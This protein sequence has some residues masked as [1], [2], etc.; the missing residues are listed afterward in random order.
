MIK[1]R[2]CFATTLMASVW[3][4]E[5]VALTYTVKIV[6]MTSLTLLVIVVVL[7]SIIVLLLL[8]LI[9]VLVAM[10]VVVSIVIV[11]MLALLTDDVFGCHCG[12]PPAMPIGG[13][14]PG[15]KLLFGGG[16]RIP[17]PYVPAPIGPMPGPRG[18]F[19]LGF[20]GPIPGGPE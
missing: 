10:M 7:L 12:R 5:K 15:P 19:I 18:G 3:I 20:I 14:P 6:K 13:I 9:A 1:S 17:G 2:A 16:P 11:V 4:N 8:L